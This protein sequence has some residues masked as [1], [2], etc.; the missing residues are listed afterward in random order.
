MVSVDFV[1]GAATTT[2]KAIL[3]QFWPVVA[4]SLGVSLLATPLCR[5][6]ALRKGIVDRPDD[7][8]KPHKVPIPYLGGV[9][10]FAGWL[11]GILVSLLDA[12]ATV[13]K[14]Q[15]L[16][17]AAAGA[18]TML[19]GLFDDLRFMRPTIKLACNITVAV[20]LL[21][22]GLGD[23][24]I[25]VFTG[26]IIPRNEPLARWL[27]LV[28]SV[29]IV[30]FIVVGACNATNLIDGLDGLCAGVLGII[31]IGFAILAIHM[32][33]YSNVDVD[34]ERIVLALAMLG[35]AAGFLPFNMNPAKIFLGDAGSMLLGLNAAVLI[36]LFAERQ[37]VL[38][39]IGA[40]M[41]F[42]LPIADML[43]TLARRWRNGKPLMIGDRSHFYDQLRDR[44]LSVR[45]VVAI[46]YLL[47]LAFVLIGI[48]VIFLRT[49]YAILVYGL[50]CLGV[51]AAVW[52]FDMVGIENRRQNENN[53]PGSGTDKSPS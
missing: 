50:T 8:L 24:I 1:L 4:V 15:I 49:R 2:W 44:G 10:V 25:Q 48:S 18:A 41:V 51:V 30:L 29:P 43:L 42:G 9:A 47:T 28:Y 26:L 20:W 11:A 3:S 19:V 45:Q 17:V 12:H 34:N 38:W 53:T 32:R 52:K 16:G 33:M 40:L 13:Q 21:F 35:A 22:F 23:H 31:S 5:H 7:F 6:A 27:E 39:M 36:L 14:C 37:L 46:S